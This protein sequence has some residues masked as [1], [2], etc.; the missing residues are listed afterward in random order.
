MGPGA[1]S[2]TCRAR[3]HTAAVVFNLERLARPT[4]PAMIAGDPD[5][6]PRRSAHKHTQGAKTHPSAGGTVAEEYG[7][8]QG[9]GR[10]GRG[11]R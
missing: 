9:V 6:L 2:L 1:D 8:E 11:R 4:T 5:H 3:P 10:G 7:V